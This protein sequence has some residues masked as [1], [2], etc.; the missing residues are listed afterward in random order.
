L[1][2]VIGTLVAAGIGASATYFNSV[3]DREAQAQRADRSELRRVLDEAA[4][5]L[6][7][8][9]KRW[10]AVLARRE[11]PHPGRPDR[12][13]RPLNGQL[14]TLAASYTRLTIRL[15]SGATASRRF[16]AALSQAA[17]VDRIEHLIDL[18]P[19]EINAAT[20]AL[21]LYAGY[22]IDFTK[23]AQNLVGSQLR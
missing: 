5:R 16:V 21:K 19:S 10:G 1:I 13:L 15:G 11:S 12:F 14:D 22:G 3:G 9:G 8:G 20:A 6:Y 17:E 4:G 18:G 2:A 23:D 7:T